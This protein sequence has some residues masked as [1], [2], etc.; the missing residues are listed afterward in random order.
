MRTAQIIGQ[1]IRNYRMQKK[2]SQEE[3]AELAGCHHTYIGQVERGEKNATI[4]SVDRIAAALG[5]SLSK[6][7]EFLGSEKPKE[8]DYAYLAYEFISS[9]D[10]SRQKM[11]YDIILTIDKYRN[12]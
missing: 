2:L 12:G 7:F 9:K 4:E 1:R 10:S 3:L 6:L 5:I 8:D 11:L